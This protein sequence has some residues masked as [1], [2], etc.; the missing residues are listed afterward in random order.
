MIMRQLALKRQGDQILKKVD[1]TR[2]L[3]PWTHLFLFSSVLWIIFGMLEYE[4]GKIW[5]VRLLS[6][7][8]KRYYGILSDNIEHIRVFQ[9]KLDDFF[10]HPIPCEN[11]PS[12]SC[13]CEV[14]N[15]NCREQRLNNPCFVLDEKR[16]FQSTLT[17]AGTVRMSVLCGNIHQNERREPFIKCYISQWLSL[18]G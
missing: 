16:I 8:N 15:F 10:F 18:E 6:A 2:K 1:R 7:I 13:F 12:T 14:C 5:T 11:E 17:R 4:I 9:E 3:D